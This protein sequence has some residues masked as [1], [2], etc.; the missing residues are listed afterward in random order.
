MVL[1]TGRENHYYPWN[2]ENE[3]WEKKPLINSFLPSKPIQLSLISKILHKWVGEPYLGKKNGCYL[4]LNRKWKNTS[5]F[6]SKTPSFCPLFCPVGDFPTNESKT[7]YQS[8]PRDR[9]ALNAQQH[10]S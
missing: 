2:M 3:I 9:K 5:K 4:F 8:F 10:R 1:K 6:E 7:S